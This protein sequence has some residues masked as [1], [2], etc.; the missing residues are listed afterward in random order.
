VN[1]RLFIEGGGDTKKL[2]IECRQAFNT[3]L[4]SCGFQGRMPRLTA[5]GS[6]NAAFDDFVTAHQR[7]Q[8]AYVAL[9]V[10]SEEP[11][12]DTNRT[13]EHLESRD[14]W[15][16]PKG[17]KDEQ[18]LLMTTC[19]ETWIIADKETLKLHYGHCLQESALPPLAGIEAKPRQ[20]VQGQLSHATR[21]CKNRYLKGRRSFELFGKLSP[22]NLN[23]SH[24][25][26]Y[27]RMRMVLAEHL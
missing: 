21:N 22:E 25:P 24:L 4:R 12:R 9:L 6:R 15:K 23:T 16:R 26:S 8:E 11:V 19:M 27:Q 3:F 17:A 14:G 18:V 20:I 10:D 13:W 7:N 1:A 5:C 2:R